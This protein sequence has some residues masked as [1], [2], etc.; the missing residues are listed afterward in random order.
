M[1]VCIRLQILVR[2]VKLRIQL[3]AL[4]HIW[5][6]TELLI[7]SLTPL[8]IDNIAGTQKQPRLSPFRPNLTET[9]CWKLK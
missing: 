5:I 7:Q 3:Q 1:P 2:Q 8:Y 6:F 4:V 9:K